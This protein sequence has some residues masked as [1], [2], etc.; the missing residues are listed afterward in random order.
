LP[1]GPPAFH[2]DTMTTGAR[3]TRARGPGCSWPTDRRR[4][5]IRAAG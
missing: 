1:D 4:R 3:G 5:R 2:D